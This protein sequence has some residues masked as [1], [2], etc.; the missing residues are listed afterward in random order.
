MWL[1]TV[2]EKQILTL[3]LEDTFLEKPQGGIKLTP[4]LFS[5]I[6]E[7]NLKTKKQLIYPLHRIPDILLILNV[8]DHLMHYPL[9]EFPFIIWRDRQVLRRYLKN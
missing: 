8:F 5:V 2:T 4:N 3:F 6:A 7:F 9:F 1:L